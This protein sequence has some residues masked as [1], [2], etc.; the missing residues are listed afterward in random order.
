[1][2]SPLPRYLMV[3]CCQDEEH[4]PKRIQGN[5]R[6]T[7][8]SGLERTKKNIKHLVERANMLNCK[9]D[10]PLWLLASP[11]KLSEAEILNIISKGWGKEKI[12]SSIIMVG[13]SVVNH[14][15]TKQKGV[16]LLS[17]IPE[18]QKLYA[19]LRN[20]SP[21]ASCRGNGAKYQ[22]K[23]MSERCIGPFIGCQQF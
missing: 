14:P 1:M 13:L 12:A 4:S 8:I 9:V 2:L 18:W 11:K 15:T 6:S 5:F 22:R 20:K 17:D 23:L 7:F 16:G 3:G 19:A 10:N 21:G